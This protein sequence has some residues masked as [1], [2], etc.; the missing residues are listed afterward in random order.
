VVIK[1]SRKA[2]ETADF[3]GCF[4]VAFLLLFCCFSVA[5]LLLIGGFSAAFES[6][7]RKPEVAT[8]AR[9]GHDRTQ[10]A[11]LAVNPAFQT[12]RMREF[13]RPSPVGRVFSRA[14]RL[15]QHADRVDFDRLFSSPSRMGPFDAVHSSL[16]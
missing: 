15:M 8:G 14:G 6:L 13:H 4:S 7:Y 3:F 10:V 12:G 16:M 11:V 1:R 9:Q 5:F 2:R